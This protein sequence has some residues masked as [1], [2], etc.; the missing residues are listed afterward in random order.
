[1]EINNLDTALHAGENILEQRVIPLIKIS[2]TNEQNIQ[3]LKSLLHFLPLPNELDAENP[4]PTEELEVKDY[5][6]FSFIFE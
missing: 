4:E 2:N 1:M 5:I 3:E 6:D